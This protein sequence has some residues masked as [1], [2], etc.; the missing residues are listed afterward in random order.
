MFHSKLAS[1]VFL[2]PGQHHVARAGVRIRTLLG[3]CVSITLWHPLRQIGAMSH[4]LLS[5]R[6][7]AVPAALDGR[8]AKEAMALM[9]RA[10]A[11][12]GVAARECQGKLFGGGDMFPWQAHT[13]ANTI[14]QQNGEAAR[15]LLQEHAIAIVS[16]SLFG[17]GYREIIFDT[18]TG[19]VWQRQVTPSDPVEP[20]AKKVE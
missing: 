11:R 10:L 3:S 4:F 9:L 14:G 12:D 16:E 15:A 18:A 19:D 5:N 2:Q 8:Y 6:V 20:V 7:G 1:D 13:S 17:I